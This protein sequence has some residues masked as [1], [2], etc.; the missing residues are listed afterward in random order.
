MDNFRLIYYCLLLLSLIL[1][2]AVKKYEKEL[3][4]FPYL[5]GASLFAD[6]LTLLLSYNEINFY[7]VYHFYIPIEYVFWIYYFY[8]INDKKIVKKVLLYSVPTFMLLCLFVS[9]NLTQIDGFPNIQLNIEGILLIIVATYSIFTIEIKKNISVF[10]R[11]VFWV[12]VAVLIYYTSI[13]PFTAL[14]NFILESK[15]HLYK[16]FKLYLQFIP[17]YI[18]YICLSIAFICSN[19]IKK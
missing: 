7:I 1:S 16:V 2:I 5:L 19:R 18:L 3:T 6:I 15:G 17:N 10:S 4:V 9:I 13:S 14:Y 8:A 12:C 11:P